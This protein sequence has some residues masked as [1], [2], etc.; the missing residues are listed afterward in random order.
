[1]PGLRVERCQEELSKRAVLRAEA[2]GFKSARLRAKAVQV[3][4]NERTAK[5]TLTLS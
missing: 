3:E 1:M 2:D 4:P 5:G